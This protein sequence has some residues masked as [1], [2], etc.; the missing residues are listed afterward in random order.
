M[1]NLL[2]LIDSDLHGESR[3]P[4]GRWDYWPF[5]RERFGKAAEL[6]EQDVAGTLSGLYRAGSPDAVGKQA[7]T[8]DVRAKDGRFGSD[9]LPPADPS[10]TI[11]LD[12]EF[13]V[14]MAAFTATGFAG[15]AAW[16]MHGEANTAFTAQAKD[17]GRLSLPALL[18]HG[19]WDTV[20]ETAR[21]RLAEPMRAD[22]ADLTEATAE[23]G[24]M[25]M[26]ERPDAVNAAIAGWLRNKRLDRGER[27]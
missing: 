19:A 24:H 10:G 16:Y 17:S 14:P 20:C 26:I 8:A 9:P 18:L 13:T 12:D 23:A 5:Y 2:P 6:F 25:L 11:L 22:C 27:G 4:V 1:P 15:A 7:I 21:G 3:Y